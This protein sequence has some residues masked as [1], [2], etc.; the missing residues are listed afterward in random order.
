[1]EAEKKT[2]LEALQN[3][4]NWNFGFWLCAT[5]SKCVQVEEKWNRVFKV[6]CFSLGLLAKHWFWPLFWEKSMTRRIVEFLSTK[7]NDKKIRPRF[8]GSS[9]RFISIAPTRI[10]TRM[11]VD[12]VRM[13]G[14]HWFKFDDHA[15]DSGKMTT[16]MG[17]N[18]ISEKFSDS[19]IN[20]VRVSLCETHLTSTRPFS[21]ST[22]DILISPALFPSRQQHCSA[23]RCSAVQCTAVAASQAG[24]SQAVVSVG[25]Y[26]CATATFLPPGHSASKRLRQKHFLFVRMLWEATM[27]CFN[28]KSVLNLC[29][30]QSDPADFNQLA[31]HTYKRGGSYFLGLSAFP[32][33]ALT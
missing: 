19:A 1:M 29:R 30:P 12:T 16:A 20:I 22:P 14:K 8:F 18:S 7:T 32:S 31:E 33:F 21:S 23:E 15:E 24:N 28:V 6:V 4:I 10:D 2:K 17:M 9:L 5:W 26:R 13:W 27:L 3:R 11:S 25:I